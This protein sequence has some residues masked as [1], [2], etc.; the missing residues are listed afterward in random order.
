VGLLLAV[1]TGAAANQELT[2]A[3]Q[4]GLDVI[5]LDHHIYQERP[6]AVALVNPHSP[7]SPYP[8]SELCGVAVAFKL[9]QALRMHDSACLPAACEFEVLDLVALG[10][11]GDQMPLRGENRNLVR[12]GLARMQDRKEIRPGLAALLAVAGLEPGFPLTTGDLAYQ[13]A[14]RLNACGRIGRVR[15]ALELL[16]TRDEAV[17]RRLAAEADATNQ[18]RRQADH[19]LTEKA[20]ALAEPYLARGDRGLV[21]ADP[22]WHK[23]IIGIGASRLVEQFQVPTILIAEEDT[24]ARGSAR[25]VPAVD[26]KAVLDDCAQ[27]LIRHGGHAQAAGLTLRSQDIPAFREAF[28]DVLKQKPQDGPVPTS[29]DLDLPLEEMTAADMNDLL[30]ELEQLEPIGIGNRRPLF[31]AGG[32]RL[33]RPPQP[34]GDGSHLRFAFRGPSVSSAAGSP[35]LIREFVSFGSGNAWR[36]WLA[37]GAAEIADLETQKWDILFQIS[38]STFRPRGGVYDPVQQQLVDLRPA[39][40]A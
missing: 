29:Y 27:W 36:R 19:I 3:R 39:G 20:L 32:L 25:S 6:P 8:N 34:L 10:L 28:L 21:L 24:E 9:L 40:K 5:V 15:T 11:V 23:G 16:Q 7:N 14:P 33:L 38:R 31:R 12:L 26:V 37:D 2:R 13:I 18:Q 4:L 35:A 17:A 22:D 30:S 1:D